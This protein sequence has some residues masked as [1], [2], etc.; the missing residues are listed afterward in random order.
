MDEALPIGKVDTLPDEGKYEGDMVLHEEERCGSGV[1]AI[2]LKSAVLSTPRILQPRFTPTR[3]RPSLASVPGTQADWLNQT[4]SSGTWILQTGGAP[5]PEL[6]RFIVTADDFTDTSDLSKAKYISVHAYGGGDFIHYQYEKPGDTLQVYGNPLS[7]DEVGSFGIYE[8][9]EITEHNFPDNLG[10][11][12][13][14]LN[15]AFTTYTV[16]P[17][18]YY[19]TVEKDELCQIKT[20]PPVGSGATSVVVSGDAPRHAWDGD[21]WFNTTDTSPMCTTAVSGFGCTS[22]QLGRH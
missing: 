22:R 20:M 3:L 19:G 8:I 10:E 2:G 7:G 13:A 1:K 15:N 14:D 9:E 17:L 6:Q 16:K 5:N 12:G 4:Y 11:D 21:L 18:A